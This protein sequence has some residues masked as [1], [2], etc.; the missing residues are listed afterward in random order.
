MNDG[1]NGA[2]KEG[3]HVASC[4]RTLCADLPLEAAIARIAERQ[5]GI[6]AL[7]QLQALGLSA[8]A[9]R[10]RV[11]DGRL[12]R[13]QRGVY[14]VR[15]PRLT[16]KGRWMAAVLAYGP[17]AVLSH[18]SAAALWGIHGSDGANA[19]VTLPSQSVRTRSGIEV[20]RSATL[21][22]ADLA[23]VDGIP[24]TAVARTLV[25]FADLAPP[26]QVERAVDRAEALKLF[27]LPAVEGAIVRAGRRRG[28]GLLSAVLADYAGPTPTEEGLEEPFFALCRTAS[29]P[30]PEVNAWITLDEGVAYKADFL[31]RAERLVVETDGRDVHSTRRAFEHDR[32][33]DQRLTLAG[34]TVVRFTWRQVAQEPHRVLRTT[35]R[36]LARLAHP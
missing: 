9:V 19:D 5:H 33:R 29:L 2:V 28:A 17:T 30:E 31:W 35:R 8:S 18:R 23:Q 32:L 26:R 13:V 27:D 16:R 20:H 11:A 14:A 1:S 25:D 21:T 7:F 12:Y 6:V 24:C 4:E 10:N 22:D 3:S 36:L 34:F 15:H